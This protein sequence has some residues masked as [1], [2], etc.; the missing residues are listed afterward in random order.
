MTLSGSRLFVTEAGKRTETTLDGD[1]AILAAYRKYFGM[2]LARP[3]VSPPT[4]TVI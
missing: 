4:V 3:P 1:D 2:E